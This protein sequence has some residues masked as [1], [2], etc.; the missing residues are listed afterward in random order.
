VRNFD[1]EFFL[2]MTESK[3][4]RRDI[5]SLF[6][7]VDGPLDTKEARAI[8]VKNCNVLEELFPKDSS[9]MP[10]IATAKKLRECAVVTMSYTLYYNTDYTPRLK[11]ICEKLD[12]IVFPKKEKEW[13]SFV[14]G[15]GSLVLY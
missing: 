14:L 10:D 12:K 6:S 3:T 9:N 13:L 4:T 5:T 8:V 7:W 1:F 15:D 2:K 11:A